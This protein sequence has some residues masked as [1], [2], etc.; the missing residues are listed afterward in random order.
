MRPKSSETACRC[1]ILE[2]MAI[3]Q[4][5]PDWPTDIKLKTW[6]KHQGEGEYGALVEQFF[7]A[8]QGDS[9]E[10]ALA[11]AQEL[12]ISY[13]NT[14]VEDGSSFQDAIRPIPRSLRWKLEAENLISKVTSLSRTP[15]LRVQV[16]E[17]EAELNEQ[18]RFVPA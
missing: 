15:D 4:A 2:S 8:G 10:S 9:P 7:I 14:F 18:H 1:V 12:T 13:L 17:S 16:R 3:S 6:I 5:G 11:N